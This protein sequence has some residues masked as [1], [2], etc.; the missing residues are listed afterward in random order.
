MGRDALVE[1]VG[2]G[3][4]ESRADVVRGDVGAVI[5]VQGP[6]RFVTFVGGSCWVPI[7]DLVEWTPRD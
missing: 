4:E 1:Y 7:D 5:R 3:I 2:R 6:D